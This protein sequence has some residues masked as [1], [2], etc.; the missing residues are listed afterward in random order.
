MVE[1]GV[2]AE[3]DPVELIDGVLVDMVPTAAEHD[4][5]MA[6]LNRHLA[7]VETGAWEVRGSTACCSS[8]AATSCPTRP[9]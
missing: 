4:G 8:R 1:A 5:A 9:S 6:W 3:N 7:R 2:F